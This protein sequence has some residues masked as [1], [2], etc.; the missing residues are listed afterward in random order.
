MAA[1]QLVRDVEGLLNKA[2]G[3]QKIKLEQF[4][5]H[6][7]RPMVRAVEEKNDSLLCA[8]LDFRGPVESLLPS[9]LAPQWTALVGV[10]RP[11][12]TEESIEGFKATLGMNLVFAK[13]T[14]RPRK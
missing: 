2:K 9:N 5:L 12:P 6:F 4:L 7:G 8:L 13:R 14:M 1:R 11:G 3:D 10:T